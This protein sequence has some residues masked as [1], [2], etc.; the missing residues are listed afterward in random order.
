MS[1]MHARS[2]A[3]VVIAAA[4]AVY[5]APAGAQPDDEQEIEM[6]PDPVGSGSGSAEGSATPPPPDAAPTKDPKLAKKLVVAAVQSTQ[7]GDYLTRN[8]RPD[9]AKPHYEA[10]LI[11]YQKAIEFGDD[12]NVYFDLAVIEDKLGKT[13]EAARHWRLVTKAE[14]A[15]PDVVKKATTKLEEAMTK[16]GLVLLIVKPEGSTIELAGVEV[17]KSPLAEPLILVPGT[18]TFKLTS[19]GFNPKDIELNV[20]AGSESERQVDLEPIPV[21]I[22]PPV[23][24]D[25]PIETPPPP[26]Q[27][28]MM[29]IYIGGGATVALGLTATITGILAV[30]KHGTFTAGDSSAGERNDARDAGKRFALISDLTLVGALG[31]AGFTAYWYFFKYKPAQGKLATEQV[32]K[33]TVVPWVQPHTQEGGLSLLGRF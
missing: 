2:I 8:K 24:D 25:E 7:K 1:A 9:D 30:G 31:A 23:V 14:G 18:Y 6:D 19:D 10:A 29:P 21:V 16:L 5:A 13:D 26:K 15:R 32:P 12:I 4:F 3:V 22:E 17:G 27:V 28:S 20:E 33:V 11:A